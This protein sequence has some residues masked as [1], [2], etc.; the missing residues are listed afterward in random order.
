MPIVHT[1]LLL[2][3]LGLGLGLQLTCR[4]SLVFPN[5]GSSSPSDPKTPLAPV[6]TLTL[7]SVLLSPLVL[8]AL[9][10]SSLLP[11]FSSELPTP[12]FSFYSPIYRLRWV[13]AL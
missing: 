1:Q 2:N 6:N 5:K 12:H 13:E 4:V 11:I 8:L 9:S 3:G 10:L 7:L